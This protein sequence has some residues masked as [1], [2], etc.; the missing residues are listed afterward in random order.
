MRHI[1]FTDCIHCTLAN[2]TAADLYRANIEMP[3]STQP[4]H[5]RSEVLFPGS[6]AASDKTSRQNVEL[7]VIE[8]KIVLSQQIHTFVLFFLNGQFQN[9]LCCLSWH[10]LRDMLYFGARTESGEGPDAKVLAAG[11]RAEKY[12]HLTRTEDNTLT[13]YERSEMLPRGSSEAKYI[14]CDVLQ[15]GK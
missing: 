11:N 15:Q 12:S 1:N 13:W 14:V 3:N 2:S 5:E 4:L 10:E 6:S 9:M 8:Q 7:L